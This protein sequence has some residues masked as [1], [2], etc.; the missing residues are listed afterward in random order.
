M[1]T[2]S[3]FLKVFSGVLLDS[4]DKLREEDDVGL[5][6]RLPDLVVRQFQ[7]LEPRM[8]FTQMKRSKLT[9]DI[10]YLRLFFCEHCSQKVC[11]QSEHTYLFTQ[12]L[13]FRLMKTDRGLP[14]KR[15]SKELESGV[16]EKFNR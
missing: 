11:C 1:A 6:D 10:L 2:A 16:L 8:L 13:L 12:V 4:L 7:I 3:T 5:L 9:M 15:I 14:L